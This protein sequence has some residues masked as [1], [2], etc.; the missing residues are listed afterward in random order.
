MQAA[1]PLHDNDA[2]SRLLQ[3]RLYYYTDLPYY[4][5]DLFYYLTELFYYLVGLFN[6]PTNLFHYP[7]YLPDRTVSSLCD[8]LT[9][10]PPLV[11]AP[12]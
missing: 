4:P 1:L 12:P 11:Y 6:Y 8:T 7:T 10:P 5:T 9:N 2:N 3:H